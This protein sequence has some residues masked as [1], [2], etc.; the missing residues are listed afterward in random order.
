MAASAGNLT[1]R[2]L[3]QIGDSDP[4]QVAEVPVPV[5]VTISRDA[6]S[7]GVR[8]TVNLDDAKIWADIATALRTASDRI[9]KL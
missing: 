3:V 4:Q 5:S 8:G 9:A 7:G 2:V 6:L 1:A